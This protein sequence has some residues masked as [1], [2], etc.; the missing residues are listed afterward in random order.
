MVTS[1]VVMAAIG[2]A[3]V[4][5]W[6]SREV[7]TPGGEIEG[8]T[9][10]L[11]RGL[12][13]DYLRVT[14]TDVTEQA[15]IHF[16]HFSGQ[17]TIQLPEDMGSGLAWG[18]YD[19]D[20]FDDVFIANFSGNIDMSEVQL[21]NSAAVSQL[22]HNNKNGTFTEVGEYAGLALKKWANGC[23]WGDYDSDGLLDLV[24][25]CYGKN[26]L[27]HNNGDGT[28]SD[29]S[30]KSG[31]GKFEGFWTGVNWGDYNMDGK[32]DLYVCGYVNYQKSANLGELRQGIEAVANGGTYFGPAAA[33]SIR[34]LMTGT[35]GSAT[36]RD[37]LTD[38]EREILKLIAESHSTKQIAAR[39]G[40]SAK[41]A[42][43]HRTNL[44]R[45]LDLHD[46]AGLTRFA[47][48][49]GLV[50]APKLPG[51]DEDPSP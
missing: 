29:M 5:R 30:E 35:A 4:I 50:E 37:L 24:V 7:Y 31:I 48:Q 9:S 36:S 49:I 33:Q 1:I 39:L 15:G 2:V 42:D 51:M 13:E 32:I 19:N 12:P 47:I 22:Y 6:N 45:K 23:A 21:I 28:F 10:E 3:L 44:M 40:L 46:V 41:T 43:N 8:L 18:D 25:S 20:G 27:F 17:R 11:T 34:N 26:M 14:F 38:R 16:N